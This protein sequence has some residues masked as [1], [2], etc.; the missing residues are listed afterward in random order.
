MAKRH[1][2]L[3]AEQV[4]ELTNAYH[5]CKDGPTRSR[6]QAVRLYSSGYLVGEILTIVGCGRTSLMDWCRLY[7]SQGTA[8]LV[9]KRVGGNHAHLRSAQMADLRQRLC[10]YSPRQVLGA[11]TATAD[12]QF[13]TVVDLQAAVELWYGVTY[14]SH[15]S[16]L[17]LLTVCGF[18]YQRPAR[19]FKSRREAEV[20]DFQEALE[21]N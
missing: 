20:M 19:V 13:W 4:Q 12:G 17:H 3:T 7:R 6:Y 10:T 15:S 5:Q 16:Y 14:Q 11:T 2:Q 21:K 1:F 9:D 8:G 18:S